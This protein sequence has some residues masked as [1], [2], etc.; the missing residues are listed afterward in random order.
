[1][2]IVKLLLQYG[3]CPKIIKRGGSIILLEI[4]EFQIRFLTSNNYVNGSVYDLCHQFNIKFDPEFFP[5]NFLTKENF[6]YVGV[7]PDIKYFFSFND[8][9]TMRSQKLKFVEDH[10]IQQNWNFRKSFANYYSQNVELLAKAMLSFMNESFHFQFVLQKSVEKKFVNPFN[11]P[12]CTLGSFVFL[13]FKLFYLNNVPI[14]A[15]P[16]EYGV[17]HKNV[18]SLEYKYCAF[19]DFLHPEKKFV[20]AF[21]NPEGAQ[22]F[23]ECIPDLYSPI[24]KEAF[25]FNRCYYHGH[26]ENCSINPNAKASSIHPF[27]LTYDD[28]NS[29]FFRKVEELMKNHTSISKVT[30]QWE[31]HFK[32]RL[33][34]TTAKLFLDKFSPHCL[35]RFK[36]RDTVRGALSDV[37][38]LR[39]S[40]VSNPNQKIF[41]LD[42]NGL[43]SY[44]AN[45]FKYMTGKF[46]T[47][48]GSTLRDLQILRNEVFY[49]DKKVTGA[50]LLKILPPQTLFAPFLLYRK[51]DGTTVNTLCKTCSELYIKNCK[52]RDDERAFLGTYMISEVEFALSLGYKILQIYEAHVYISS[53]FILKDFIQKVNYYKTLNTNCFD[54]SMSNLEKEKYADLLNQKME[55]R[56]PAYRI[57]CTN[58]KPNE[59][60][61]NFYKL[62]SN[63][64][65]GKFIQRS[66]NLEIAFIKSQEELEEIYFSK[67]TIKD[68]TCPNEN[69]CMLFLDKDVM[70][71]PP[72]RKQNVDIG[73][74]ITAYARQIIYE[75]LQTILNTKVCKVF[76]I[77]CDSIYFSCPSDFSCPLPISHA[78]GDFKI[79]YS[80]TILNY[81]AFGPKHYCINFL[82]STNGVENVCKYSGLSLKNE[83]NQSLITNDTFEKYLNDFLLQTHSYMQLWQSI[84]QNDFK[85]F[86]SRQKMQKFSFQN[87][88]SKRRILDANDKNCLTTYPYGFT[89]L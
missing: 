70:K 21:N 48:I 15:V 6:D 86:T 9:S 74:Q 32:E 89:K 53:E 5:E 82:N 18:S 75:H 3:I 77:E 56:D 83:L 76:Q 41:C 33:K 40:K 73:S 45:K 17:K 4:P 63:A 2:A 61:R 28:M 84:Q 85:K 43:Y 26:Y 23:P 69:I 49:K 88:V 30:I 19:M 55:I 64:L 68:F 25:F 59:A 50:I 80:R 65:F 72:N 51:K 78:L 81:H 67:Q 87:K 20:Y 34:S 22:Y 29:N 31:C 79:E 12:I 71:L 11:N 27:G 10:K 52:H 47:L 35:V 57:N 1:M 66:D 8:S 37:Y 44:C 7:I 46:E 39:W 16:K 62:L 36:P 58:V 13:I 54:K 42:V 24:T 38:A 14:F 60:C